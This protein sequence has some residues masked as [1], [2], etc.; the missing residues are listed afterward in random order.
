MS[1]WCSWF[2]KYCRLCVC[3]FEACASDF[4][5]YS[6]LGED[7]MFWLSGSRDH[8]CQTEPPWD[9]WL[10]YKSMLMKRRNAG[11]WLADQHPVVSPKRLLRFHQIRTRLSSEQSRR[12]GYSAPSHF[13]IGSRPSVKSYFETFLGCEVY[14]GHLPAE[15]G[16]GLSGFRSS[17][18]GAEFSA[19]CVV[20]QCLRRACLFQGNFTACLSV[21]MDAWWRFSQRPVIEAVRNDMPWPR[22]SI[23]GNDDF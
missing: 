11:L 23:C 3:F 8:S 10:W 14:A 20:L 19:V 15:R 5:A 6:T 22:S 13:I 18:A 2:L 16:V 9:D 1:V 21:C 4:S 17:E 7:Q 12:G